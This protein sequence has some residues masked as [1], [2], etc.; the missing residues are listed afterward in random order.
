[1]E[2][3]DLA[4]RKPTR[5]LG[6]DGRGITQRGAYRRGPPAHARAAA[7]PA[8]IGGPGK[9]KSREAASEDLPENGGGILLILEGRGWCLCACA[10]LVLLPSR[11][12]CS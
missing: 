8:G 1:M 4:P 7:R 5:G 2:F 12:C 10:K 3:L 11:R 9:R 6:T